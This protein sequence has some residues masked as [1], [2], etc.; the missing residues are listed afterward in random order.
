MNPRIGQSL[1]AQAGP[2]IQL[3]NHWFTPGRPPMPLTCYPVPDLR[4]GAT[5]AR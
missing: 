2:Q 3:P 4:S 5:L 1:L